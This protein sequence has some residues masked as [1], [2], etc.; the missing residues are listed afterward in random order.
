MQIEQY[1]RAIHRLEADTT[2]QRTLFA[3]ALV[4]AAPAVIAQSPVY[5][6]VSKGK[7]VYSESPCPVGTNKQSKLD[8]TPEYMGN[9]TYSRDTINS[10]RARIRAGMN[11]TGVAV[12]T[13][14]GKR[15][16]DQLCNAIT[17]DLQNLDSR[18]RQP[19]SAWEQDYIRQEKIR[20]HQ[21]A[22]EWDC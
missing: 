21:A 15:K 13:G 14:K 9:E 12:S 11:E 20:V 6:C 18:S 19:L 5:K 7:T 1:N 2:M 10:A 22:T 3:F 8:T 4:L 16:N 17:R